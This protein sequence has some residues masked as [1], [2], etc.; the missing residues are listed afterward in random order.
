MPVTLSGIVSVP[1]N[2]IGGL[3]ID[4]SGNLWALGLSSTTNP[5]TITALKSTDDG[6]TFPSSFASTG[7]T[8]SDFVSSILD[9]TNGIIYCLVVVSGVVQIWKFTISTTTWARADSG[10]GPSPTSGNVY[11][12]DRRA[13]D[14]TF[15]VSYQGPNHTSMGSGHTSAYM[16]R[17][18]SGAWVAGVELDAG[19]TSDFLPKGVVIG[20][21]NVAYLFWMNTA[22]GQ[23]S[24]NTLSTSNVLGTAVLVGSVTDPNNANSQPKYDANLG[25]VI[26]GPENTNSRLSGSTWTNDS[27]NV[28]NGLSGQGL[29]A[30]STA[31][32]Y[33]SANSKLYYFYRGSV[34][35]DV[36]YNS[37]TTTTW[38]TA[39]NCMTLSFNGGTCAVLISAGV[40]GFMAQD[41]TNSVVYF[42]K[43][44]SS[45]TANT[46][47]A[48]ITS[49]T[50]VSGS[51][52][53]SSYP[54]NYS[55]IPTSRV[56]FGFV[57]STSDDFNYA[58]PTENT[59]N[60]S[61]W[62]AGDSTL[63]AGAPSRW[64]SHLLGG[65]PYSDIVW[66]VDHQNITGTAGT[67]RNSQF[68]GDIGA[69]NG[70]AL[71]NGEA[72]IT[73]TTPP[74]GSDELGIGLI[75]NVDALASYG[76]LAK[77]TPSGVQLYKGDSS[78]TTWTSIA[79]PWSLTPAA[80]DRICIQKFGTFVSV[81]YQPAFQDWELLGGVNDS[82]YSSMGEAWVWAVGNTGRM[83]D[84]AVSDASQ[85][86]SKV[87]QKI[88]SGV[89]TVS[90][91]ETYTSGNTTDAA[92][93][94]SK[95]T[96]SSVESYSASEGTPDDF[97]TSGLPNDSPVD[98]T[99][100][101]TAQKVGQGFTPDISANMIGGSIYLT[102]HGTP[103]DTITVEVQSSASGLPSGTVL[104]SVTLSLGSLVAGVETEVPFTFS[105][106]LAVT[107]GTEYFF[108]I[109]RTG[110]AD[111]VNFFTVSFSDA[112][113]LSGAAQFS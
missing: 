10:T 109:Y 9:S 73:I 44:G 83:D 7:L 70:A 106:P 100:A 39:T 94:T 92:T 23:V 14:G 4:G 22:T 53:Q 52:A 59:I 3:H 5:S 79:G 20:P 28:S 11:G 21:S 102:K 25:I 49:K 108:V 30:V 18:T 101:N 96:P 66:K 51:E 90:G 91:S 55:Q 93:I 107:G 105:S 63:G 6:S 87:D 27:N 36:Y 60:P 54:A 85:I 12:F 58:D 29:S 98:V 46:D 68:G 71:L 17:Y 19:G 80:G 75:G 24:Y 56:Q 37:T 84:F 69:G 97:D 86:F 104:A 40:I 31:F 34:D 113:A 88:I 47:S 67:Q 48:T 81:W 41:G 26:Y 95:T 50:T 78:T 72:L 42:D 35:H 8:C 89:T 61:A 57:Q 110:S 103:S 112:Q 82:T 76:Y 62:A 99:N 45:G 38:G 77:L 13:S 15:V 111:A 64:F 74:S 1:D 2:G 43:L 33:D 16:A 32:V 65:D